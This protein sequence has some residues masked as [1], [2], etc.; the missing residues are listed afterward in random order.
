MRSIIKRKDE[1]MNLKQSTFKGS[2]WELV[3]KSILMSLGTTFSLFIATPWLVAWYSKWYWS[4]VVIDEQKLKF[5]GKGDDLFHI[6]VYIIVSILTVGIGSL[7]MLAWLERKTI[8]H[9]HF[10]DLDDVG[11]VELQLLDELKSLY[12]SGLI[13]EKTYN[14]KKEKYLEE[15]Y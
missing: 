2:N 1:I 12:D 11:T 9:I 5:T 6:Y 14:D 13:D 4:N 8:K 3:W 15:N 7:F 10:C